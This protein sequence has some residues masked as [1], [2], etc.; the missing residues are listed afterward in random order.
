MNIKKVTVFLTIFLLLIS[1]CSITCF[2]S[3]PSLEYEDVQEGHFDEAADG[4]GLTV[5]DDPDYKGTFICFDVNEN[6]EF[7]ICYRKEN[8]GYL[9][10]YDS[11]G[12]FLVGFSFYEDGTFGCW[13]DEEYLT[14]Y[15]LRGDRAYT[16]DRSGVIIDIKDVKQT[17]SNDKVWREQINNSCRIVGT[18]NYLAQSYGLKSR[19]VRFGRYTTLD[20]I[21]QDGESVRLY[22]ASGLSAFAPI[23]LL[24]FTVL[25][26]IVSQIIVAILIIKKE[27]KP[28]KERTEE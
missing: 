1:I 18:D 26:F 15:S 27:N 16:F 25:L 11:E 12:R 17:A 8:K 5:I 14:I 3:T 2:A 24:I 28:V 23:A 19:I 20:K 4:L 9:L 6:G 10:L 13:I 21:S 22:E 7:A